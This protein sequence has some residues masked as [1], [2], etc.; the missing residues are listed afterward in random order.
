MSRDP[1]SISP[2][3]VIAQRV[4][5]VRGRKG[6]NAAQLGKE[7]SKHGVRWDRFTVANLENGKRQNVTVQELMALALALGVAPINLLV[8]LGDEQYEITPS[9]TEGAD[10]VRAWVRG[11]VAL[12]GTDEW[13]F[14]AEVSMEDRRKWI[15]AYKER[16]DIGPHPEDEPLAAKM[17]REAERMRSQNKTI[18]EWERRQDGDDQDE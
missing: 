12:P 3:A 7:V 17:H 15:E 18:A 1:R 2:I 8:P 11:E 13:M 4:K 5:E 14:F 10:T 6:W 16:L 9:R